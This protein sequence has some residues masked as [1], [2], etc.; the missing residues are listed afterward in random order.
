MSYFAAFACYLVA[1]ALKVYQQRNVQFTDY[2][3]MPAV[4]YGM[5]GTE[6]IM[7]YCVILHFE[8]LSALLI[9]W[10]AMGSGGALGSVIGTWLHARNH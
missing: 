5:A 10:F 8:S 4:S 1:V 9:L 3:K 7:S 6:I 2:K